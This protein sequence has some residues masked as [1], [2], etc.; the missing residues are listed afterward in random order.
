MISRPYLPAVVLL[1]LSEFLYLLLYTS[2][3]D[4]IVLFIAV[5]LLNSV[6]YVAVM[7]LAQRQRPGDSKALIG[8][9]VCFGIVFRLTLLALEPIASDDIYRYIWDGKVQANG[10]DPYR[11]APTDPRLSHLRSEL[12]PERINHPE[13]KTIYPPLAQGIFLLSYHLG[14]ES[15]ALFKTPLLV[16]EAMTLWLLL[17][18]LDRMR[19]PRILV[20]LY[21]ICPLPIMQFMIDGHVDGFVFPFILLALLLWTHRRNRFSEMI[22]GLAAAVKLLPILFIPVFFKQESRFRRLYPLLVPMGILAAF[23]APSVL[24]FDGS[25]FESLGIFTSQWVFNGSIYHLLRPFAG[26]HQATVLALLVLLGGWVLYLYL[27]RRPFV[28]GLF[29]TVFGFFLLSPTVQPWYL[30]WI[31][32][33]LPLSFRWSA[34][35]FVVLVNLANIVLIEYSETGLWSESWLILVLQYAPVFGILL[36]E[37]VGNRGGT[38]RGHP[39][40][41]PF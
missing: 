30:T 12:L 38:G 41:S 14:Q 22:L 9:I 7:V 24:I 29:L 28:E 10:I 25:P 3:L 8:V 21:A 33:F 17:L 23:Y 1:V 19:K 13:L 18:L 11:Y 26:S 5:S 37:V 31:A 34:L 15:P 20:G 2:I 36:W 16:A 35:T 6:V 39:V 32:V 4:S 40:Q 27:T